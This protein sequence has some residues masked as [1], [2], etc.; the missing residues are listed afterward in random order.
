MKLHDLTV[1]DII[2]QNARLFGAKA[3]W[4][5]TDTGRSL[6]FSDV[7]Q[8]VD[9]MARGLQ[10]A[11]IEKGDRIGIIGKNCLE[12]FVLFGAAASLGGIAVPI[13][14]RLAADET[15]YNLNDTRPR[16][17]FAEHEAQAYL[18]AVRTKVPDAR[19]YNLR[20]GNGFLDDFPV[21]D[22]GTTEAASSEVT[23]DDGLVIIHTAAVA[24]RPRGALLSH[25][26]L[27][28]ADLHLMHCFGVTPDDVHFNL[29]PLFHIAGFAMALMS[30]HAGALNI[31]VPKFEAARAVEL[32]AEHKVTLLFEFAPILQSILDA[33]AA[34]KLPIGSLRGIMG[35]DAAETIERY[36]SV[37]GGTFYTLYGQTETSLLTTT[38][39]YNDCPGGAGRPLPL[40]TVSIVDPA[41]RPV[42]QGAVG[43]IVM[44]GPMVFQGYWQ[45][46]GDNAETFRNNWHHTGDM[47]HLDANGYLWYDGRKPEKELIKPGGENVYPAEVETVILQHPA[48]EDVVVFGV[49]DPKWKEGIKAVC[50]LK[51]GQTLTG[52]ELIDFV[53]QRIARYKKPQY[54]QFIDQFP[55]DAKG[56]IDR[57]GTKTLYGGDGT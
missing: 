41:D 6:T 26:N 39:R 34:S 36:Q 20:P 7:K 28:C 33:Q 24:G 13:N 30:F 27:L 5:D 3:A 38:G 18:D 31:N 45:L 4:I 37:A 23:S 16:L 40:S 8:A 54:V 46:P 22:S 25:G 10:Q 1:N 12:Y 44:R 43:E 9:Q 53:G 42:P 51:A 48:V 15:A 19:F 50:T 47:G 49:P 57:A 32:I 35:L 55:L 29:L 17:V 21:D 2:D 56:T 14:W 52:R 11:G